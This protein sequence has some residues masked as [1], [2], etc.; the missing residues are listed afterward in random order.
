MSDEQW[1]A[2]FTV[3][4]RVLG[5][6]NHR[7]TEHGSW[8][9]WTTFTSLQ[10]QVHYWSAGVPLASELHPVGTTD[11]GTWGQPFNFRDLAHVIIPR[12]VY[13]EVTGTP[14]FHHGTKLQDIE[15]LSRELDA[16]NVP[17]RLTE[18]VLEIKR[19]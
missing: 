6:G 3:C 10:E 18:L 14:E 5:P 2:F 13:W 8:C 12:E 4:A 17:H 19:Y 15:R 1:F 16:V 9:A 7:P 11:G